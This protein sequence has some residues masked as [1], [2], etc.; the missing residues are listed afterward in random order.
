[1]SGAGLRLS[2]VHA[3]AVAALRADATLVAL[4]G[5]TAR[6]YSLVPLNTPAPYVVVGVGSVSAWVAAMG[7]D[8]S[9]GRELDLVV[10]CFSLQHGSVQADDVA[11]RATIVLESDAV[12]AG[13]AGYAGCAFRVSPEPQRQQIDGQAMTSR[14]VYVRV[15]LS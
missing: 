3:A 8:Q 1:M 4:L 13:V 7:A 10:E 15:W 5:G 14:K 12:F 11:H 9:A 6:V 2:S